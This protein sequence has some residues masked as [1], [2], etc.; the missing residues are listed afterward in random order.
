[1]NCERVKE[2]LFEY[3]NNELDDVN[4]RMI[5]EHLMA[6]EECRKEYENDNQSPFY[7][8]DGR[9]PNIPCTSKT[10]YRPLQEQ[11]DAYIEALKD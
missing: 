1:M 6:C 3:I 11:I 2:I 7:Y 8:T 10:D 4:V 5:R 9:T